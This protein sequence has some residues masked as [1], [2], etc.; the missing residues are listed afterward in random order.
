MTDGRS[1]V[2]FVTGAS[3]G[4]GAEAAVK[5]AE[6][7]FDVVATAR[8]VTDAD[9]PTLEQPGGPAVQVSGSLQTTAARIEGAGQRALPIRIDLTDRDSVLA[10]ADEAERVFGQVDVL[11]N[12]AVYQ[13]PGNMAPLLGTPIEQI[14]TTIQ[15]DVLSMVALLQRLLPGMVERGHGVVV[16]VTSAVAFLEPP[17]PVGKGGWGFAYGV[18][19]GA[20]D[21]M[22]GLINA[23]L[24]DSG[25][26]AYNIEP[27]FVAYGEKLERAATSYPGVEVTPPEAIGAAIAWL[28][29]SEDATRFRN[30]RV[31]GPE[32]ARDKGLL[33]D[34]P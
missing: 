8:T 15:A 30:K 2:A 21:R 22:A 14:E 6:A 3:R 13:G 1:P 25:V 18:S 17:A 23:E 4:I 9:A 5:L 27:G 26:I 29:T 12:N 19:K 28:V 32:L 24:G 11:V 10:A 7:G 20:C 16:D 31:H 34:W 33:A